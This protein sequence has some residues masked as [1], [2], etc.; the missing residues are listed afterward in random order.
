[1]DSEANLIWV[2]MEFT[3]LDPG[4][5]RIL[6]VA[7]SVTDSSLNLV[8]EG[9]VI[10]LWQPET[11]LAGLDGWN[12]TH[13]GESGLL[14]R[15]R[16]SGEDE[17]SASE[18]TLKFLRLHCT[19]G[20]SPMCGNSVHVDRM[21]MRAYMPELEGFFHYRNVDVSTVKELVRRWYPLLKQY[22]KRKTHQ[23]LEDI[24]ESIGELSYYRET[25]FRQ[26]I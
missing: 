15:V 18:K 26:S 6:E 5:D 2:D 20:K 3:G 10:A 22:P 21:F 23:A 8:A 24:R 13:H 16:Q 4:R 14:E 17:V 7:T 25:V 11:V 12:R 9:P 19:A 1:M